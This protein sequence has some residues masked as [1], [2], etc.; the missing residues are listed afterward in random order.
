M[1]KINDTTFEA[2]INGVT[3][4]ITAPVVGP[5]QNK[6]YTYVIKDAEQHGQST[7]Q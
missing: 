5:K 6:T 3:Y 2:T 4:V 1:I 7:N